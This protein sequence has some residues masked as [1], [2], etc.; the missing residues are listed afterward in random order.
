MQKERSDIERTKRASLIGKLRPLGYAF[1]TGAICGAAI[2]LFTVCARIVTSFTFSAYNDR[3][4]VLTAV[5]IAILVIL[6]C[7]LAAVVQTLIPQ[8]RGSGIPLAMGSAR[9]MLRVKWL[10]SAAGLIAGSMLSF[11]AGVGLGSEGPSIGLGGLIGEGVGR[12]GKKP[13]EFRRGLITGGASAGLAVA[14]NAPLT[15]VAFALEETHKRFSP[16]ILISAFAAVIPAVLVSQ[17]LLLGLG[18]TALGAEYGI[19][20]GQCALPFLAQ[21]DYASFIDILC[22]CGVAAACGVACGILAA[23]FNRG[24]FLL[25]KLYGKIRRPLWRLLP[26]FALTAALGLAFGKC[27]G[28]GEA[29]LAHTDITTSAWIVTALLIARFALTVSA[30]G[31]GTTGGLFLPMIAIG[32]LFGTLAAKAAVAC[33]ISEA[34]APNMIMLSVGAFFAASSHAPISAI[35]MT[36]ELTASF[37]N[38]LPCAVAVAASVCVAALLGSKPLYERMTESLYESTET[39]PDGK[40]IEAM[41]VVPLGSVICG[42]RIRDI[43]WPY[44][45]LVT[46]L[47][48]NGRDIVPDG[49]TTIESGDRLTVRAE[50]VQSETFFEQISEYIELKE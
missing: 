21:T 40:T 3:A 22:V 41:G 14:F 10:R 15:G 32:G 19:G 50:K 36:A 26:T 20:A 49:E 37:T 2:T 38:L 29:T 6:C 31:S 5:C 4:A 34:Y 33:G 24:I 48:R 8:S 11:A 1:I 18:K 23:A 28:S 13:V 47:D 7:L 16:S 17:L 43:L 30:S 44:N 45:S 25:S 46:A 39:P 12:A 42:K 35:V 9:G 27:V